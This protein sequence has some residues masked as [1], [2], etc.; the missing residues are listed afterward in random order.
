LH[1]LFFAIVLSHVAISTSKAFIT[2]GIGNAKTIKTIDIV[3]KVICIATF[4][5]CTI[6]FYLCLFVGVVK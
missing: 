1:P 6:G 3:L 2:L 4:I 5:A